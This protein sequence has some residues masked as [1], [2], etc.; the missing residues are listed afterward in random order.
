MTNPD[1][2]M[3][4]VGLVMEDRQEELTRHLSQ[5]PD[6]VNV[7]YS[8]ERL[9]LLHL[10]ATEGKLAMVK[11]L[12]AFGAQVSL[13]TLSGHSPLLFAALGNHKEVV[14]YLLEKGATPNEPSMFNQQNFSPQIEQLLQQA[15]QMTNS[16]NIPPYTISSQDRPFV[17]VNMNEILTSRKTQVAKEQLYQSAAAGELVS[18]LDGA[19]TLTDPAQFGAILDV[20]RKFEQ[21]SKSNVRKEYHFEDV[22]Q[23]SAVAA[24]WLNHAGEQRA[25]GE[26]LVAAYLYLQ[27]RHLAE[28]KKLQKLV[29]LESIL[30]P[31]M[32]EAIICG[33][34]AR[35]RSN[36]FFVFLFIFQ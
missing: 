21:V 8:N 29:D 5:Y 27:L 26:V 28:S 2:A 19:Q 14:Q 13:I 22:Q 31:F 3:H 7:L 36:N 9:S 23:L 32:V 12:I 25:Y 15:R 20:L 35:L 34:F 6:Q 24:G 4:L 1:Y 18:L 30:V 16:W 11:Q 10:A 17:D 33:L